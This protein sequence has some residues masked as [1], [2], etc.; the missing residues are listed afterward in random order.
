MEEIPEIP[1]DLDEDI[2]QNQTDDIDIDQIEE[3]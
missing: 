1:E 2:F 3:N